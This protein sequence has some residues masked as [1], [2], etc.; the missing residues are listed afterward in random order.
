MES[1]SIFDYLGVRT[2]ASGTRLAHEPMSRFTRPLATLVPQVPGNMLVPSGERVGIVLRGKTEHAEL[3][4]DSKSQ[5]CSAP[6]EDSAS[7][8]SI[9]LRL[10]NVC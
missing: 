5:C 2:R 6:D 8:D 9:V 3:V 10:D 7:E 4:I 1:V